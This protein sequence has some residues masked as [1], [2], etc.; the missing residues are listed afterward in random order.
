MNELN[1]LVA[2]RVMGWPTIDDDAPYRIHV[3]MGGVV[4][5][6]GPPQRFKS[7]GVIPEAWHP[8]NNMSDAWEVVEAMREKGYIV[9]ISQCDVSLYKVS[10]VKLGSPGV[11]FYD[12]KATIAICM[13]A[14]DAI[15]ASDDELEAAFK[16]VKQ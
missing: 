9:R 1:R 5:G 7:L 3:N 16:G 13:A 4:E 15:G 10:F 2:E 12:E 14:L 6:S 8:V 11:A